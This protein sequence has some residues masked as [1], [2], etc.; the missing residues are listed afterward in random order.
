MGKGEIIIYQ[1]PDGTANL[2]VRLENE[3]IWLTQAQIANL[4][5]V[6]QPAVSKRLKN[7]FILEE[8]EQSSV[9]SIL[10]YTA[11]DG[12]VYRT[13]FYNLDAILSIGYRVN[14]KNATQFRIWANRVLKEYLVKGYAINQRAQ[15]AQLCGF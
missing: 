15:V 1:L 7:I 11:S 12:K 6:K 4:F 3:T 14:S 10:E 2:D 8:L 13:S 9:H 5:G